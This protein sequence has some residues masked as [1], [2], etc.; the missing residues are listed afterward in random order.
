MVRRIAFVLMACLPAATL[1]GDKDQKLS[2]IELTAQAV[3]ASRLTQAGGA[4]FHLKA[5]V[6]EPGNRDSAYKAEI[7]EDWVAPDKWRRTI[8]TPGFTQSLIVNG[9][10]VAEV[11][12]GDYYPFWLRYMV[13]ALFDVVPQEFSPR[14][15]QVD[16][17]ALAKLANPMMRDN[18]QL[19]GDPASPHIISGA[20]SRWDDKVGVGPAQNTV[21]STVCFV[22]L[23][24]LSALSTPYYNARF[25]EYEGF[26]QRQVARR[27]KVNLEP[28]KIIE[29]KVTELRELH[30]PDEAWFVVQQTTSENDWTHSLRIREPDARNL[31]LDSPEITWAP[32]SGG[33]TS[34]TLSMVVYIDKSGNVRETRPLN[35][36][37]SDSL[38]QA[39]KAVAQWH[40]KPQERNGAPVQMETLLT[41]PFQTTVGGVF[42]LL[43]NDQARKLAISK[44]EASISHPKFAKGTEYAVRIAVNEQGLVTDIEDVN[45]LDPQ[46]LTA[47]HAALSLWFFNPYK[48]NGKPQKFHADIIFH[49][50]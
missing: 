32:V 12:S 4:P 10:K 8:K 34:G 20:C 31:L 29:A 46:L 44:P 2:L 1:A 27:I 15:L 30:Q 19:T 39:R 21:F 45:H 9:D 22:D 28:G 11:D 23:K 50:K 35:S 14:D 13:T 42:P 3:R 49:V 18:M 25:E 16:T 41:F 26:K 48:Q 43:S 5:I 7:E 36:D 38:E 33:K 6:S 17:A 24:L 40:F 37:N 47:A